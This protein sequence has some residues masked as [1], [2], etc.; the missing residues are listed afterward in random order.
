MGGDGCG[1]A[2]VAAGQVG[3]ARVRSAPAIVA[4][5]LA[6]VLGGY[7]FVWSFV[8]FGIAAVT[9]AGSVFH[10]AETFFNPLAFLVY[11]G[12]FLWA[13]AARRVLAVLAG[14][15]LAMGKG[16][17]SCYLSPEELAE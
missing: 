1:A 2:T 6:T 9:A 4:R 3:G 14:G 15:A 8:A 17:L 11:L 5:V 10:E 7:A 16:N 12:L 13:F